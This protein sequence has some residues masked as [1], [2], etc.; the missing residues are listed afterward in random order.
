MQLAACINNTFD[1]RTLAIV[2]E[3]PPEFIDEALAREASEGLIT[4]SEGRYRFLHDRIQ[5]AAYSLVPDSAKAQMH[6][7]IGVLLYNTSEK[8]VE[9][10]L[11][12]IADH[13]NSALELIS[14][15]EDR[16]RLAGLNLRAGKK[17]RSAAAYER[18]YEYLT[19]A[20]GLLN[21]DCWDN[22][23]DLMLDLHLEAAE[24]AYACTRFDVMERAARGGWVV[25]RSA[26]RT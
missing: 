15:G 9:E 3:K 4:F 2:A 5:Q 25:K 10:R 11:F 18:A 22:Q 14:D 16:Y 1:A 8:E 23:Y 7:Q 21:D 12:E 19:L 24:A 6:Y 26:C 17:A 13:L 20:L